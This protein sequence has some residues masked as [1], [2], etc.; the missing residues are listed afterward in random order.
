MEEKVKLY[1]KYMQFRGCIVCICLF[2]LTNFCYWMI[3]II[4]GDSQQCWYCQGSTS[5]PSIHPFRGG[6]CHYSPMRMLC[7]KQS[8]HATTVFPVITTHVLGERLICFGGFK[9][10][11]LIF[12]VALNSSTLQLDNL[13]T[14]YQKRTF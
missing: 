5:I 12:G 6:S 9:L 3:V 2:L 4:T 7:H 13:I 10:W 14:P 11:N 8:S 1:I